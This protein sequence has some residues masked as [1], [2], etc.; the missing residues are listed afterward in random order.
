MTRWP[1]WLVAG[2]LVGAGLLGAAP[3]A[4]E[5]DSPLAVSDVRTSDGELSFTLTAHGL[6]PGAELDGSG[7]TVDLDGTPVRATVV[8]APEPSPTAAP[9]RT[10]VLVL[11][12]SGSMEGARLT[13]AKA[14]AGGYAD[15]LPADVRLGL[16]SVSDRPATVLE[17]SADR[18]AF[19]AAVAGLKARGGTALYDGVRQAAGLLTGGGQ[20]RIVVLSDGVD[21]NST[22]PP[23]AVGAQLAG[24]G[25]TLDGIAYGPDASSPAM[26]ALATG[27]GGRM[28]TAGDAASLR[29]AFAGIAAA[30]R[31]PVAAVTV[32]VPGRLAGADATLHVALTAGGTTLTSAATSVSLPAGPGPVAVSVPRSPRWPLYLGLAATVVAVPLAAFAGMYLLVR[33]STVRT[34]LRQL[35]SFGS[36]AGP[37][38]RARE[39]SSVLRAALSA[40]EYAITR[41]GLGG[42]IQADL[43]RAGINLR[44]AEWMLARAGGAALSG[45][46]FAV[47]LPWLLGLLLGAA[48]GWL[49]TG[50]YRR[51]RAAR[52]ARR[53]N[54]ELPDALQLVV[55]AL[56]SGFSFPQAI[57]ALVAEGDEAVS[58]EFGRALAETRL[59]GEL[60]EALLRVAERNSS[61]D[62]AWL[63]MA[64]RVQ[65][66][67]GG[68]L[69]E[70][71]ETAVETMRERGRLRRHVRALS[72]EGRLSAWVLVAMPVV[73]AAFMFATRREYLRPLYT[74]PLGLMMLVGSVLMMGFGTF[75]MTRVIKVEV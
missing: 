4:A 33:R 3:A 19:R 58:G 44:P 8:P 64:I 61:D 71:L 59:G 27:T 28:V 25:I 21:T 29:T 74:T 6:P 56:R 30:L 13:A 68:G 55:S 43:D 31:P 2:L 63:V 46:L 36:A 66:E 5:P 51:L 23:A 54:D 40:S 11:D 20:R 69:S 1:R 37:A 15:A 32:T 17:P 52:R 35:D 42:R 60:E 10:V 73:L 70:V 24:A 26:T 12:T 62:L 22:A 49:G 16:V 39:E 53:F 7:L 50:L 18:T 65:R 45:V 14:A 34:R 57:A 47:L 38:L 9:E 75:W 72:A 67:V 41:R 48:V